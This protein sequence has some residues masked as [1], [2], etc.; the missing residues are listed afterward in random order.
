[1]KDTEQHLTKDEY[2]KICEAA[3]L[4]KAKLRPDLNK[5]FFYLPFEVAPCFLSQIRALAFVWRDESRYSRAE[6]GLFSA[7]NGRRIRINT[8]EELKSEIRIFKEGYLR[9]CQS[10]IREQKQ[11]KIVEIQNCGTTYE[12]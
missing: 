11:S 9:M 4:V 7:R 2:F 1:M 8:A 6:V 10:A 5:N 12:C 3:G